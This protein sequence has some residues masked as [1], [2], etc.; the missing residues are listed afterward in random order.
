MD[1]RNFFLK[2]NFCTEV[3]HCKQTSCAQSVDHILKNV[4]LGKHFDIISSGIPGLIGS[5][6]GGRGVKY[7]LSF[8]GHRGREG[9]FENARRILTEFY[10]PLGET[11]TG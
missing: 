11:F 3:C 9:I 5:R 10:N 7:N 1:A 8:D 6:M 2:R 4:V